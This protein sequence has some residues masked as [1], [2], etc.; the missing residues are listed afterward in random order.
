MDVGR[1][2]RGVGDCGEELFGYVGVRCPE[3][4]VNVLQT[5]LRGCRL[6]GSDVGTFFFGGAK[7]D[8]RGETE[9]L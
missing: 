1:L 3:W 8:D 5:C 6:T 4:N 9:L 7:V 2:I